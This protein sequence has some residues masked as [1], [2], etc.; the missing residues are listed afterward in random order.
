MTNVLRPRAI[1]HNLAPPGVDSV[2][3]ASLTVTILLGA[4]AKLQKGTVSFVMS[5]RPHGT[6]W[7][8]LDRFSRN[9]I[10]EGF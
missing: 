8:L 5:V 6:T 2:I 4:F 7:L 9:L 1:G 10:L 3:T